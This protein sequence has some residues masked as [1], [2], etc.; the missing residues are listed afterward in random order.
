MYRKDFRIILTFS[1]LVWQF[2][3]VLLE[4]HCDILQYYSHSD[5]LESEKKIK[6]L[7]LKNHLDCVQ[8]C[9]DEPGTQGVVPNRLNKWSGGSPHIVSAA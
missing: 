9:C 6:P 8:V 2:F 1:L 7:V 4:P 5:V 3:G